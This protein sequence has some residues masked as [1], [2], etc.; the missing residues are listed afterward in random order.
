MVFASSTSNTSVRLLHVTCA[1]AGALSNGA[2]ACHPVHGQAETR[3]PLILGASNASG[4]C[5]WFKLCSTQNCSQCSLTYHA[6]LA[7]TESL[8]LKLNR[9]TKL[10]QFYQIQTFFGTMADFAVG[11]GILTT[12]SSAGRSSGGSSK[13]RGTAPDAP[14]MAYTASCMDFSCTTQLTAVCQ[15]QSRK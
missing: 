11:T 4:H 15:A 14:G 1:S 7:T 12:S 10:I 13:M 6:F 3:P 2:A 5:S 8:N 9:L